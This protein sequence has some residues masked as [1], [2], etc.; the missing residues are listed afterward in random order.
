MT[1]IVPDFLVYCKQ[2]NMPSYNDLGRDYSIKLPTQTRDEPAIAIVL[3][4]LW[5]AGLLTHIGG[6][7]VHVLLVIALV[8]IIYRLVKGKKIP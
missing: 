6:P 4:I 8:L 5:L 3:L 7:V 2:G 1:K